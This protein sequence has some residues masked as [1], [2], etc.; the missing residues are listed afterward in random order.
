MMHS[1]LPT[2]IGTVHRLILPTRVPYVRSVK[3][4]EVMVKEKFILTLG[5]PPQLPVCSG[6]AN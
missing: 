6:F 1:M 4:V 2:N 5:H 3:E